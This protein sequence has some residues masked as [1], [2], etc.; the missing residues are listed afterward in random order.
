MLAGLASITSFLS[1]S[2]KRSEP[3]EEQAVFLA[4]DGSEGRVALTLIIPYEAA[5]PGLAHYLE[6]LVFRSAIKGLWGDTDPDTNAHTNENVIRYELSGPAG[7]LSL[8]LGTLAGVFRPITI[9]DQR[10]ADE[11]GIVMREYDYRLANDVRSRADE[12]TRPFLYSGTP[13]A[14]SVIGSPKDIQGLTLDAARRLHAASHLPGRAI[15]QVT[16]DVTMEDVT[17]AL[18]TSHFPRL[19]ALNSLYPSPALIAAPVE[20]V[21]TLWDDV[22]E[23]GLVWDEVVALPKRESFEHLMSVSELLSDILRSGLD[24]SIAKP[25]HYDGF[26]ARDIFVTVYPLDESHVE[27]YVRALPDS[28]VSLASLRAALE[29][30]LQDSAKGIPVRTFARVHKRIT[31]IWLEEPRWFVGYQL[32]RLMLNRMPATLTELK[33]I[34]DNLALADVNHLAASLVAPGRLAVVQMGREV[35]E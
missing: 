30:A 34:D 7:D 8:M 25:L 13:A 6:H 33:D 23:P 9:S 11:R 19:A 10:A 20:R 28:G 22:A 26:I 4:S 14:I 3:P 18:K 27:V 12:A 32:R 5:Q 24:G 35:Q 31:D 16:G 2:G 29:R 15:L 21:F 17:G 1:V